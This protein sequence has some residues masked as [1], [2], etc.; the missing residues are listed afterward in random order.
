MLAIGRVRGYARECTEFARVWR[1]LWNAQFDLRWIECGEFAREGRRGSSVLDREIARHRPRWCS[2]RGR[3]EPWASTLPSDAGRQAAACL[4]AR[5]RRCTRG[6][7]TGQGAGDP[8][9]ITVASPI[10][11]A[12]VFCK[13][14]PKFELKT[15]FHQN[16]SSSEFYKLQNFFW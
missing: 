2:R 10:H 14:L 16:K 5:T 4:H 9:R 12:L 3:S 13:I 15:K 8:H 11:L 1:T 6:G 7:C